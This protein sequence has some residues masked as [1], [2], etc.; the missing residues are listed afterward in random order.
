[1]F[2][3]FIYFIHAND[4]Y[5]LPLPDPTTTK[6]DPEGK[7]RPTQ[8]YDSIRMTQRPT[9]TRIAPATHHID[10]PALCFHPPAPPETHV[11]AIVRAFS[12]YFSLLARDACMSDRTHVSSFLFLFLVSETHVQLLIHVFLMC[13]F[14]H[15]IRN[16]CTRNHT[17]VS[18][19][20]FFLYLSYTMCI[21]EQNR[22]I[23]YFI[24]K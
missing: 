8:A 15:S 19:I 10:L 14:F 23:I 22:C 1:M 5:T 3:F 20:Y 21:K 6:P 4:I 7:Q 12:L 11:Q 13:Y 16:A 18:Y 24:W 2:L 17:H 9:C